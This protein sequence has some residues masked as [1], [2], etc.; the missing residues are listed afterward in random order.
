MKEEELFHT[1][2]KINFILHFLTLLKLFIKI[3]DELMKLFFFF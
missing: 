3:K 2:M 1:L